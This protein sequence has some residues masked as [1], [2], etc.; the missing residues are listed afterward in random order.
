MLHV[1]ISGFVAMHGESL[2]PELDAE[3]FQVF[4][5]RF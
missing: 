5:A 4:S 3:L 1:N 2:A